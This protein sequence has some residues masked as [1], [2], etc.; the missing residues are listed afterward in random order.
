MAISS[1]V[2]KVS[3]RS[4]AN[5]AQ[6]TVELMFEASNFQATVVVE[7]PLQ[8][9]TTNRPANNQT[10]LMLTHVA[11]PLSEAPELVVQ[12]SMLFSMVSLSSVVIPPELFSVVHSQHQATLILL[13][14]ITTTIMHKLIL[15]LHK[16]NNTCKIKRF[17]RKK[18]LTRQNLK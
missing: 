8:Q 4:S 10:Y 9:A 13:Q 7:L 1:I 5:V 14:I 6:L 18:A 12:E 16:H 11:L 17:C 3:I 2:S 15:M